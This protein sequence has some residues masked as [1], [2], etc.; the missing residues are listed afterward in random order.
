MGPTGSDA[1]LSTAITSGAP[2]H[3]AERH[4]TKADGGGKK[5][6]DLR[7]IDV[8]LIV[9][10][11]AILTERNLTRAGEAV[12]ITQPAVSGALA[13]LRRL[14]NDPLLVRSGRS[15]ELTP[16]AQELQPIVAEALEQIG[17]TLTLQPTFDPSTSNRRFYIAGSDY[18]L[19]IMTSPLLAVLREEAPSTSVEFGSLPIFTVA[20]P[21]DLLRHDVMIAAPNRGIP[22]KHVSLFSDTFVCIVSRNN[23]RLREGRLELSDLAELRHVHAGFGPERATG[24]DDA[25][26]M[27]GI[28]P[29]IAISLVGFTLVPFAV[30]G[31]S[32]VG[33]VPRRLAELYSDSLGLVIAETPLEPAVLVETAHWHPSKTNDPALTWLLDVLRKTSEIIEFGA[34]A[35]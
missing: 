35:E 13:K 16:R 24:I 31:T 2:R 21:V 33:F 10:L 8:N 12:G 20:T 34:E 15:F 25:L 22:G 18:A 32:L 26:A 14:L 4:A 9:V 30:S 23:P 27:A 19:A 28:I 29:K 5:L 1:G 17:R 11:E 3:N 7:G 6:A